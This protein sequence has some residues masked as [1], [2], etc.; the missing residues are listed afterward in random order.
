MLKDA[1]RSGYKPVPDA[2]G[3]GIATAKVLLEIC[4][5]EAT[6]TKLLVGF[7]SIGKQVV[8]SLPVQLIQNVPHTITPYFNT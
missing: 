5:P 1:E 3:E 6:F 2:F 7:L 4:W 8:D